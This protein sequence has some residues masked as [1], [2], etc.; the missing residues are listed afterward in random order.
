MNRLLAMPIVLATVAP[1]MAGDMAQLDIL[2]FSADGRIFAFEEYGVQD[3]SGFPYANR[4]YIDTATD[5]FVAGSPVRVRLDDEAATVASARE[6]ARA[7]G[8]AIVADEI[9]RT[10][11][12]YLAGFNAVTELSADADGISVNPRPVEPAID[13]ALSFKLEQFSLAAAA[14][15]CD[16]IDGITGFRLSRTDGDQGQ[17][18]VIHNDKS[19]PK[20]RGCP[21]GYR[22]GGVQTF[23]PEGGQP[24][25]AV[26]VAV[27]SFG[28]EGPDYRW[29]A[30]TG[31]L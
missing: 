17:P 2:G 19:I 21:Q 14:G 23:Y 7:Q 11:A 15:S 24:V 29:I 25:F 6:K 22:V 12:G 18:I 31:K 4:F 8:G 27:R 10:N 16:G 30:L 26:M 3:G 1:A 20:S 13:P 28:F 5:G 9:L